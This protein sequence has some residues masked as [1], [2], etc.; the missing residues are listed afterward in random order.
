[1]KAMILNKD[2]T[3][4]KDEFIRYD[5]KRGM[6]RRWATA[7]AI[8]GLALTSI[9]QADTLGLKIATV[10]WDA[11]TP[12]QPAVKL[13]DEGQN[14]IGA[15]IGLLAWPQAVQVACGIIMN[16]ITKP[17]SLALGVY[18]YNDDNYVCTLGKVLTNMQATALPKNTPQ[19][20]GVEISFDVLSNSIT[21]KFH[22][23][24]PVIPD[25]LNPV[26]IA[27][28]ASGNNDPV[29]TVNFDI[30]VVLD[31]KISGTSP[32]LSVTSAI[33]AIPA[34]GRSVSAGNFQGDVVKTVFGGVIQSSLDA[35]S[36]MDLTGMV[37][38]AL[39]TQLGSIAALMQAP[40]N[41]LL[42]NIWA[43]HNYIYIGYTP[44][45]RSGPD[46]TA[47]YVQ[48]QLTWPAANGVQVP[49]CATL[50]V[51]VDDIIGPP[52]LLNP[53]PAL[54]NQDYPHFTSTT[55]DPGAYWSSAQPMQM[56]LGNL[57][58]NYTVRASSAAAVGVSAAS[59]KVYADPS[60][61]STIIQLRFQ[62]VA[63][64]DALQTPGM[65]VNFTG[66]WSSNNVNVVRMN[67]LLPANA[68]IN[69]G[70]GQLGVNPGPADTMSPAA[71]NPSVVNAPAA[72]NA[73]VQQ[74]AAVPVAAPVLVQPLR[75]GG[76]LV[77]PN[78]AH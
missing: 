66:Q 41:Y 1:M 68:P 71:M 78:Q 6:F 29:I 47:S 70:I 9:A 50:T 48:G 2:V 39:A 33:V 46:L 56:G 13:Q 43:Q 7:V 40:P 26:V 77:A 36:K 20:N 44:K 23:P 45:P 32:V 28:I 11:K 37:Q 49:S 67:G 34:S 5:R 58:C 4:T 53:E 38:T 15:A 76:A 65:G 57:A 14:A 8:A 22:N 35:Y 18:G 10:Q 72:T 51:S 60:Q 73:G 63:N 24:Y 64:Y 52:T 62:G 21:D 55:N 17:D 12:T 3:A 27:M 42:A 69:H 25:P 54:F 61:K 19:K 75:S 31:V 16:K 30:H 59:S 74:R